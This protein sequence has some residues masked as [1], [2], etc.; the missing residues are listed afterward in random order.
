MPAGRFAAPDPVAG[1]GGARICRDQLVTK[2]HNEF[3]A[4]TWSTLAE[5]V[6]VVDQ[7]DEKRRAVAGPG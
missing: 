3:P 7:R 5:R 4:G 6:L 1:L 2:G